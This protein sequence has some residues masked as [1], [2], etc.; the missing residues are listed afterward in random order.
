M[1][2]VMN[3]VG[4]DFMINGEMFKMQD[5]LS[6]THKYDKGMHNVHYYDGRKHYV[7][8]G[9]FQQGCEIPY[10]FAEEMAARLPELRMCR[11]QRETDTK[12]FE[13]LRNGR[14]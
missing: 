9:S 12:Y 2:I 4:E 10:P 14:R 5:I 1:N 6:L 11:S 7:S 3:R 8:D 13:N